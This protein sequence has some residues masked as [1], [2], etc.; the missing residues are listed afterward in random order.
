MS[1][2]PNAYQTKEAAV[3]T[4]MAGGGG[5]GVNISQCL[6][7]EGGGVS[8]SPNAYQTKEVGCQHLPMLTRRRRWGVNI[9]QCL[10]DEGGGVSTS[11]NAY[12]TKE[13][14]CQHLPMLT[15][16]RR[17]SVSISQCLPDEGGGGDNISQCLPDEGCRSGGMRGTRNHG[18]ACPGQKVDDGVENEYSIYGHVLRVHQLPEVPLLVNEVHAT[19]NHLCQKSCSGQNDK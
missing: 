18:N 11:P 16:R 9:S 12:Q 4:K 7:D 19:V 14:G 13:V 1:T 15:R 5:G 17:W 6:P 10:P 3:K 2:S 8:T